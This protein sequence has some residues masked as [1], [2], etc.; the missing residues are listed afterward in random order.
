[1]NQSP[2][3]TGSVMPHAFPKTTSSRSASHNFQVIFGTSLNAYKKRTKQDLTTH[4][5]ATQLQ[6]C[7]SP[8]AI[9]TLLQDQVDQFDRERLTKW[10]NPTVNV[11]FALSEV[12]GE[13]IGLVNIPSIG[14]KF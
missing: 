2:T 7:D 13:G 1:M 11:L 14:H 8:R 3:P 9:L 10:L 4:P 5:L 12:L 6:A